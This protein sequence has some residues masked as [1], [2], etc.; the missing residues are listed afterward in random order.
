MTVISRHSQTV[1]SLLLVCLLPLITAACD[2][3]EILQQDTYRIDTD[4]PFYEVV[5]DLEFAITERNYRIVNTLEIGKAIKERGNPDFP[6]NT[7][8]LFCNLSF[9]GSMLAL[10]PEYLYHCPIKIS[11]RQSDGKVL[12][13]GQLFPETGYNSELDQVTNKINTHVIEIIEYAA[14]D[15][16]DA[17]D[18]S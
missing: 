11:A 14:K 6:A 18:E 16:F 10:E 9:A 1:R 13:V 17:A 8:V 15:W 7:V 12:I 2:R 4:K 3:T 5:E